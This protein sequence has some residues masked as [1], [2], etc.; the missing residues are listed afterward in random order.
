M[1]NT[2]PMNSSKATL[3]IGTSTRL[4]FSPC[5]CSQRLIDSVLHCRYVTT[6]TSGTL[7]IRQA[8]L[9]ITV[10]EISVEFEP[11]EFRDGKAVQL[12][13]CGLSL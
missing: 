1:S 6:Q 5:Y 3:F 11:N 10:A 8:L 12:E 4:S 2:S 9:N 7:I 13:G